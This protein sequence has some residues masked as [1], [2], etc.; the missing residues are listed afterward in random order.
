[1]PN[2]GQMKMNLQESHYKQVVVQRMRAEA[3]AIRLIQNKD[4]MYEKYL[5]KPQKSSVGFLV[6]EKIT[7]GST[8]KHH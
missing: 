8:G 3:E 4:D 2:K 7:S 1:M 5:K 6:I